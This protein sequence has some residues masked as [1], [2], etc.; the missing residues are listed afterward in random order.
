MDEMIG[1]SMELSTGNRACWV[2]TS[3]R[4]RPSSSGHLLPDSGGGELAKSLAMCTCV[5][6][7]GCRMSCHFG[8]GFSKSFCRQYIACSAVPG[9]RS[10]FPVS[11]DNCRA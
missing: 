3:C 5:R 2:A 8:I 4:L 10:H 1:W 9:W 11:T 6:E 7:V